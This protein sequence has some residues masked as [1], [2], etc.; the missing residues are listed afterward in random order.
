M[1]YLILGMLLVLVIMTA[2]KK[3]ATAGP[4]IPEGNQ[5]NNI[6]SDTT[7]NSTPVDDNSTQEIDE[8]LDGAVDDI[9]DW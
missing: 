5:G 1:K 8:E 9:N 7:I 4:E 3:E 6:Q 2:C